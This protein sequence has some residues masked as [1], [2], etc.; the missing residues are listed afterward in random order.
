MERSEDYGNI[1]VALAEM[2]P[3]PRSE[4]AA[5]LDERAAGG[6]QNPQRTRR[7]PLI[8]IATRLPSFTPRRLALVGVG[9]GLVAIVVSTALIASN[10]SQ[11]TSVALDSAES[12]PPH[13]IQHSELA[14][15]PTHPT[16]PGARHGVHAA[17]EIETFSR[18]TH[19]SVHGSAAYIPA[20]QRVP[21]VLVRPA[22]RDVKRAAE[23]NLLAD[24][25]AVTADSTKVFRA[26]HDVDG[27]VLHSSTTAGTDAG[28]RFEMLIPSA[29]L[30]DA[31][32]S[33]SAI[34][35]VR[36][37]REA[38]DDITAPTVATGER[39]RDSRARIDSL[40]TQLAGAETES[41]REVIEIQL[42]AERRQAVTLR[43]Q[44]DRLHRR[45]Q[46]ARVQVRIESDTKKGSGGAWGFADAIGSAGHILGIAAGV[47]LIGL[48]VLAPLAL[49]ALLIWL[50]RRTWV[51]TQR[52]QALR[53]A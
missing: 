42:R 40:L 38:S 19:S 45:I 49:L 34:D 39:L 10:D 14:A 33:I 17:P 35:E 25:A 16:S 3:A 46:Y 26:V 4:F 12:K 6:F 32:A 31:L 43:S 50:A 2:R 11:P 30:G 48:A 52:K 18:G 7:L 51:R 37:R 20:Q 47:A 44:Q 28:A 29:K 36:Y 21:N 24:P 23:I 1:A 13:Q 15:K 22:H 53:D 5:E 27:I 9:A 41:E 8:A